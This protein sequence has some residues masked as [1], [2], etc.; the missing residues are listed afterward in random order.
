MCHVTTP[1][2]SG[3]VLIIFSAA[4]QV[5]SPMNPLSCNVLSRGRLYSV[6]GLSIA[7]TGASSTAPPLTLRHFLAQ[8]WGSRTGTD[9]PTGERLT[10]GFGGDGAPAVRTAARRGRNPNVRGDAGPRDDVR[11]HR[12]VQGEEHTLP[13]DFLAYLNDVPVTRIGRNRD[14][15]ANTIHE[16]SS[17]AFRKA[18]ERAV[19]RHQ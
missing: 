16:M 10:I 12:P 3:P 6:A 13:G 11:L 17:A 9:S 14:E 8:V 2:T 5:I 7:P 1:H 15:N 18:V 4:D 19:E